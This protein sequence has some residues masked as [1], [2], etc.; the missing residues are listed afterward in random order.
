MGKD[1]LRRRCSNVSPWI[2]PIRGSPR[3]R[4]LAAIMADVN[5]AY[6]GMRS[7]P[8]VGDASP[9]NSSHLPFAE[10]GSQ[11]IERLQ[12]GRSALPRGGG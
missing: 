8:A 4:Y 12:A 1:A 10:V 6:Q 5:L 11:V 7:D 3:W 9:L 2:R